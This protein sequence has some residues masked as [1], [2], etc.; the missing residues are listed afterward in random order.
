MADLP[1]TLTLAWDAATGLY[2]LTQAPAT[3]TPP[4]PTPTPPPPG[5]QA[6]RIADL[7]ERFGVNT[8]SSTSS[9]SNTWG[10]WPADYSTASVIAAIRNLVGA[11][12]LT[13]NVR[14]YHYSDRTWQ[15]AWCQTVF[16]A[17]G[18]RFAMAV[19][20]NGSASDA[21]SM[22]SMAGGTG[23][24][25]WVEGINEP[26]TEFGDPNATPSTSTVVSPETTIAIQQAVSATEAA[27]V[28]G[29]SIVFGT[30]FPEGYIVPGYASAEQIAQVAAASK[31]ANVHFYPPHQ[32][33]VDDGSGRGGTFDDVVQG[34]SG[35]YGGQPTLITEWHPTL[36]N[37]DGHRLDPAYDAYYAACFFLSAFRLGA[38]GWFWYALFDFGKDYLSGLFPK[39][40]GVSPRPVA[41]TIRAMFTLTGDVGATKRTFAPG[42]L[43]YTV[44]G[45]PPPLPNAPNTGGHS[46]LFQNSAGTFFLFVWNAQNA[47]G[48]AAVPV[49][50]TFGQAMSS[51]RDYNVSD[52]TSTPAPVTPIQDLADASSITLQLSAAVHLLVIR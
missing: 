19:G 32:C 8:F 29:P 20:A 38:L 31:V 22:I 42:T 36:Y 34:M 15:G 26:N 7:L 46:M 10:S 1:P 45:L 5:V 12:G 44:A 24:L 3:V 51:V 47:P 49:T 16:A 27:T 6:A 4:P 14:E 33:D 39:T 13:I 48:G 9:T 11:S 23:W 37:E 18:A 17:T 52:A 30:P 35:L 50:V 43:A 21:A 40:G 28:V 25:K 41:N 2:V